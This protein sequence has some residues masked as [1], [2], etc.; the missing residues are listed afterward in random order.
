[1][2]DKNVFISLEGTKIMR[3]KLAGIITTFAL[4][5]ATL[6]TLQV[7]AAVSDWQQGVS[8]QPVGATDFA[9]ESFKRSVDQAVTDG[10]NN[11]T[12][13]IPVRQTNIQSTDVSVTNETPTDASITE[14]ARYIKTKGINVSLA[15]HVNPYDGQW[16]ALINPGD[17]GTWF[18]NYG[19]ILN[20]YATLGQNI[21]ASQYVLGTE[22]S[23]MTDPNVDASNTAYW[24]NMISAV[25][26]RYTGTVTYS[27]QHSNYKSDLMS[28]GFWPQ[29]DTIGISAYY[30]LSGEASP[31]VPAIK[32]GWDNWNN[33]QIRTI[34][35]RHNKSVQFTEVG[36]TSRDY[37]LRDPGSAF[38]LNTGYNAVVQ[39]NAYQAMFE[40]W[41][42]F[43][44][45]QGVSLWDWKSNPG[46]GG[47]GDV[48]Y[49]PQNKPAQQVMRQWFGG[50]GTAPA[51]SPTPAP[52]PSQPASYTA[53]AQT[54]GQPVANSPTTVTATISATQPVAGVIV[55]VEIYDSTGRQV[56]Q[57]A[58]D[59]QS[60]GTTT[61]TYNAQFSPAA[62]GE[63]TVKVGVFT[64]NWQSNLYWNDAVYKFVVSST[65]T[66]PSQP[67][68]SAP[69]PSQSA[70][71]TQPA[72]SATS[73]SVWW[74][75]EGV[76]VSGVQPFKAVIDGL[77]VSQYNMS[78]QVD[79]G[80]LNRMSTESGG[81]PHKLS[82]VDVTGW[83][84]NASQQYTITFVAQDLSGKEIGRKS[85]VI[86][87]I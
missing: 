53:S 11:I 73:L 72:P 16:R 76:T 17:R 45:V 28:L 75:G 12:L 77:D 66:Q 86:T 20:R 19:V 3:I 58:F 24:T 25:R 69:A 71:N 40:Y 74:P 6:P 82:Y 32:A 42:N 68:P 84:W 41:N 37:A 21:G 14:A 67:A 34:A 80:T 4:M 62:A 23:S 18:A 64:S 39:A 49:T 59:N 36:Y 70:P 26:T 5:F 27:A 85:V 47:E 30:S 9:S 48:D 38:T 60:L 15:I 87:V 79:G 31:S 43:S 54:T 46:A 52:A 1:M 33:S 22:L 35:E 61:Q 81:T 63:F 55:D 29:L 56:H 57:Q 50:G 8:I 10:V 2:C 7:D 44:Y 78:W 51:P 13:I 65:A 83:K